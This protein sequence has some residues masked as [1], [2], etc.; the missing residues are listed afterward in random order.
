MP[1]DMAAT[2]Y[3]GQTSLGV[4]A[5]PDGF[6]QMK[7]SVAIPRGGIKL[8]NNTKVV[9]LKFSPCCFGKCYHTKTKTDSMLIFLF[10][11]SN[12]VLLRVRRSGTAALLNGVK[13]RK[14]LFN[15]SGI[16]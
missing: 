3:K 7:G 1:T 2:I 16:F 14:I 12:I 4:P 10:S 6:D 8:P 15:F 9:E 13:K 11:I 5:C